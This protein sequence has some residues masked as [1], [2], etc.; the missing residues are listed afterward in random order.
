[1]FEKKRH[2]SGVYLLLVFCS[3]FFSYLLTVLP[4]FP[5]LGLSIF[6][7]LLATL[8]FIFKKQKTIYNLT[9]Y[10]L[11]CIT[12]LFIFIR[13]NPFLTFLNF[14]AVCFLGTWLILGENGQNSFINLIFSPLNLVSKTL[15]TK[16]KYKF[17]WSYLKFKNK[18]IDGKRL[19]SA[20]SSVL[21]TLFVLAVV[22]PLLSYAN[23]FFKDL[24]IKFFKFFD[25]RKLFE[26]FLEKSFVLYSWRAV[27]FLI[28]LGLLPRMLSWAN[29]R[30]KIKPAVKFIKL[31]HLLVPKIALAIILAIFFV[32]QTQL[33]FATEET[34]KTL[35]YTHSQ[36]AREVF[37]HLGIVS[38][39]VFGLIYNDNKK[40]ALNKT[41]TWFLIIQGIFL[42]SLALKSVYD[43]STKWGFTYKRLYGYTFVIW[44]YGIFLFFTLKYL[45]KQKNLLFIRSLSIFSSLVLLGI[46]LANFDFL[47]YHK[48]QS[49]TGEGID[50]YYLSHLSVDSHSFKEQLDILLE[51][52]NQVDLNKKDKA[53]YSNADAA[54][55]LTVKM[56]NLKAK[57]ESLPWQSFNLSEY[58]EYRKIKNVENL[59]QLQAD[60]S[61][62]MNYVAPIKKEETNSKKEQGN[63]VNQVITIT[64]ENLDKDFYN[65]YY[66]ILTPEK[67]ILDSGSL[68]GNRFFHILG[69][70]KF[71]VTLYKQMQN[72]TGDWLVVKDIIYSINNNENTTKNISATY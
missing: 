54:I 68:H 45:R 8:V 13:A 18:Q 33:Y 31:N 35:G 6:F 47:V 25:F 64:I 29:K 52:I 56:Q 55:R 60:L 30:K 59:N 63:S 61:Q 32:T 46:N 15:Q 38:L 20:A 1:M 14:T 17:D 48:S 67:K 41:I 24:L 43:Y 62:K 69:P 27:I 72:G 50:Y 3:A 42:N 49:R 28:F 9:F 66:Q 40:K 58:R 16:N 11:T 51:K 19:N 5:Y 26:K 53:F 7:I 34:L 23:P 57:Y 36:Y 65:Y 44:L 22:V 10:L 39:I 4:F 21:I 71:Y 12:A 70:G 2:Y 37:A